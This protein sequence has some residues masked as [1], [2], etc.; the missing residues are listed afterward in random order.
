MDHSSYTDEQ[1]ERVRHR[2]RAYQCMACY[3]QKEE[4]WV[5]EIGKL[6]DHILR[7]H[8]PPERIP[9]FC[10]LC[11][12]KCLKQDQL[13]RHV[14]HY[15]RH[16]SMAASRRIIDHGSYL[17]RSTDPH[18][19]SDLDV[20]K[21]SQDDSLEFFL[22]K[23]TTS[24]SVDASVNR[25]VNGT[26]DGDITQET[27]QSGFINVG[28]QL[29][30]S[31]PVPETAFKPLML[32]PG[33]SQSVATALPVLG[34]TSLFRPQ[35]S[36]PV[37]VPTPSSVPASQSVATALPVLGH[38]SLFRPQPSQ[39]VVPVPVPRPSSVP[40]VSPLNVV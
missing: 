11:K 25:M 8:I 27:L 10:Q 2:G 34:H 29:P 3:F 35:P 26:L 24:S 39:P 19:I 40:A 15:A 20:F 9:F 32:S 4:K 6:E 23:G 33:A 18:E 14:T 31:G 13:V 21:W 28:G 30:A 22:E 17:C 12:F 5:D 38:P 1:I 7:N 37:Q 16:V 36:Q